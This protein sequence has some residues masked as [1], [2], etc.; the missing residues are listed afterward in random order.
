M[1]T[2]AG[3]PQPVKLFRELN[4]GETFRTTWRGKIGDFMTTDQIRAAPDS[5][6]S[7][8]YRAAVHLESGAGVWLAD[9]Q[10]VEPTDMKAGPA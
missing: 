4:A 1:K 7:W 6:K 9:I 5:P 10:M 3:V 2:T 8:D